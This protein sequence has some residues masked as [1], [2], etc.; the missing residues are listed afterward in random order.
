MVGVAGVPWGC[1]CLGWRGCRGW[2]GCWEWRGSLGV[3]RVGGGV[4]WV[5]WV[6]P[7][8]AREWLGCRWGGAGG[9]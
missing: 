4:V 8:G 3:P 1:G 5:V 6:V 9:A 2:R 7:G